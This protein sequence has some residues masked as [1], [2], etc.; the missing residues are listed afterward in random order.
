MPK[1][2]NKP[3]W[4]HVSVRALSNTLSAFIHVCFL[5]EMLLNVQTSSQINLSIN[6]F[7]LYTYRDEKRTRNVLKFQNLEVY[8]QNKLFPFEVQAVNLLK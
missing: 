3:I 4:T 5:L 8:Q 2:S 7:F 1:Y 6:I